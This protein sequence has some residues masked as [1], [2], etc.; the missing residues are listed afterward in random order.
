[1]PT[2]LIHH[3]QNPFLHVPR[4]HFRTKERYYSGV[5]YGQNE[6]IERT[7]MQVNGGKNERRFPHPLCPRLGLDPGRAPTEAGITQAAKPAFV[8]K[9][10]ADGASRLHLS[11]DILGD[12]TGEFF[13]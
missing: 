13:S 3:H 1:M 11:A 4:R 7:D 5:G 9:H 12:P 10:Q 8:P 2:G 6:G